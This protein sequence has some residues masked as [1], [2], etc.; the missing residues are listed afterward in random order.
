MGTD[1]REVFRMVAMRTEGRQP[2]ETVPDLILR[3]HDVRSEVDAILDAGLPEGPLTD[4]QRKLLIALHQRLAASGAIERLATLNLEEIDAKGVAFLHTNVLYVGRNATIAE[5]RED[6][7]FLA[8]AA[9][10][11][12]T[13]RLNKL[14]PGANSDPALLERIVR[15]CAQLYADGDAM[16]SRY[17][18]V[19]VPLRPTDRERALIR[20]HREE[21]KPADDDRPIPGA[22]PTTVQA[23]VAAALTYRKYDDLAARFDEIIA[24]DYL[25]AQTAKPD[26]VGPLSDISDVRPRSLKA[27]KRSSAIRSLGAQARQAL[28]EL[29]ARYGD[30]QPLDQAS[31]QLA[32]LRAAVVADLSAI[33]ELGLGD[34]VDDTLPPPEALPVP[35]ADGAV[36]ALGWGDLVVATERL[37]GYRASEISHIE[38]VLPGEVKKREHQL[39]KSDEITEESEIETSSE[40]ERSLET[41]NRFEL[42][43][44]ASRTIRD[45]F[46]IT[47]GVNMSGSYGL[48][49]VEASFSASA[50]RSVEDSR[51]TASRVAK[52]VISKTVERTAKAARSL[53]RRVLRTEWSDLNTH[54]ID[55]SHRESARAESIAGVYKWLT[56]VQEVQLRHYGTRL[57]IEFTIPEPA[58]SLFD[59]EAAAAGTV[60]KPPAFELSAADIQEHTYLAL[61]RKF[62]AIDVEPPPP[63][64][65]KVG[66]AWA[67]APD[68]GADEDTAEDVLAE[69][70]Q[71]PDGYIPMSGRVTLSAHPSQ[72]QHFQAR[73]HLGDLATIVVTGSGDADR[74]FVLSSVPGDVAWNGGLPVSLTAHGH[75]DKTLS[76]NIVLNCRITDKGFASWQIKTYAALKSAHT[77]TMNDYEE[78]LQ[79][80]RIETTFALGLDGRPAAVNRRME[81]EELQ[82][83]ATAIL[84][85]RPANHDAVTSFGTGPAQHI[86]IDPGRADRLSPLVRFYEQAFEWANMTYFFFPYFW[87]RR[88]AYRARQTVLHDDPVF[89]AFLRSGCA[90]AV[91]PVTPGHEAG[92]LFYLS[93]YALPEQ[94]RLIGAERASAAESEPA[95]IETGSY[96]GLWLE[97]MLAKHADRARGSGYLALEQDST[98]A[99]LVDSHWTPTERDIGRE[100]LI[101]GV[102]YAIAA[103]IDAI[104]F[105][106]DRPYEGVTTPRTVYATGSVPFGAP[107]RVELP[108]NLV[109][110]ADRAGQLETQV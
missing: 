67:S 94:D 93:N 46:S 12:E 106:L 10:A 39:R 110:L 44:E 62:G 11:C 78:A 13:W 8:D 65:K 68:E 52:D 4:D 18:D 15:A 74:F 43:I 51:N 59:R 66:F 75:F 55:N 60:P 92:V 96:D 2:S 58:L 25:R 69:M 98:T 1:S 100:I 48:T 21:P 26:D 82:K 109:I 88:S 5:L 64:T 47:S 83:W 107:W 76:L 87:G 3:S 57:L 99:T 20:S 103:P 102:S 28:D 35:V 97:L 34:R 23:P 90:R 104:R 6:E 38:N 40:S 9:T 7:K 85:R 42:Q 101:E 105:A 81:R 71:I 84:R 16:R 95:S 79:Q 45:E 70:I 86:E 53:R 73:L 50:T 80:A 72:A 31:S 14:L 91:V 19:G 37:V 56:K 61:A 77:K 29:T 17:R 27:A 108:T 63:R 32:N 33:Y 89:E 30:E 54:A 22:L 49:D 36:Q 41:A 24:I